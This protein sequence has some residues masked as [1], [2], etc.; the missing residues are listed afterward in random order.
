[1]VDVHADPR[2]LTVS[3][4]VQRA[5]EIVD[6]DRESESLTALY[7]RL[8]DDDEPIVAVGPEIGERLG[9]VVPDALDDVDV[10]LAMAR[11]VIVYLAHRRDE[12]D[13]DAD[14]IL[15]LAARAE[16]QGR[17]PAPVADWLRARGVDLR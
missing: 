4:V 15:K 9:G 8:E 6:P 2:P 14:E 13:D 10:P 12:V 3:E 5:V 1:L 17:P 7:E 16:F 11:A